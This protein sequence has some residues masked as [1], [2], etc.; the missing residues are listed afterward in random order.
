MR[1]LLDEAVKF[2]KPIFK[3]CLWDVIEKCNGRDC[4]TCPLAED[5]KGQAKTA[6]GYY[7]IDDAITIKQ[8]SPSKNWRLE[9][10]CEDP[11]TATSK[12]TGCRYF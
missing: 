2:K 4:N 3:W 9:M 5:C 7:S 8:R 6:N 12:S 10:L 1:K 11:K